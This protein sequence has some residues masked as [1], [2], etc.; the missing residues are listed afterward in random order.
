MGL[1]LLFPTWDRAQTFARTYAEKDV[2]TQVI[3]A[4]SVA[5]NTFN[6]G[7]VRGPC[8]ARSTRPRSSTA[9][10]GA[11]WTRPPERADH[12]GPRPGRQRLPVRP[13]RR[14]LFAGSL[15]AATRAILAE[16]E[17]R[18]EAREE[19]ARLERDRERIE[20]DYEIDMARK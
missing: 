4:V 13:R 17:R 2:I 12:Q 3:D 14:P 10:G 18:K 11:R 7:L 5:E 8:T 16:S 20:Q 15:L 6:E 9:S 1:L 19:A